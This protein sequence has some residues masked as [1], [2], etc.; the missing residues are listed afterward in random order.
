[1]HAGRVS[2][3]VRPDVWDGRFFGLVHAS[4]KVPIPDT[5]SCFVSEVNVFDLGRYRMLPIEFLDPGKAP[6]HTS[7]WDLTEHVSRRETK[8]FVVSVIRY[9]V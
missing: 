9:M 4:M 2:A 5:P 6:R 7:L 8:C 1:M 3:Q